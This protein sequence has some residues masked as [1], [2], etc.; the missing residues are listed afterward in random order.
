MALIMPARDSAPIKSYLLRPAERAATAASTGATFRTVDGAA[1]LQPF[2]ADRTFLCLHYCLTAAGQLLPCMAA[3]AAP[4]GPAAAKAAAAGAPAATPAGSPCSVA[5]CELAVAQSNVQIGILIRKG[6]GG[7][8]PARA[9]TRSPMLLA[10]ETL[11]AIH[12]C[13]C[14]IC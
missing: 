8:S 3:S 9:V 14:I 2:L 12:C 1:G 11:S 4:P 7:T 10:Y 13:L 5:H 6:I